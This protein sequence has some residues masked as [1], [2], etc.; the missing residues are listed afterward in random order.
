MS[1]LNMPFLLGVLRAITNA[2]VPIPNH[3]LANALGVH[4]ATVR[5]AVKRA[6]SVLFVVVVTSRH[7]YERVSDWGLLNEARIMGQVQV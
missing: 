2:P 3:R 1:A 7:G 4:P 5:L 6:R